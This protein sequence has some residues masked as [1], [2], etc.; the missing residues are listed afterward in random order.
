MKSRIVRSVSFASSCLL[1]VLSIN[2]TPVHAD[3]P[4]PVSE[5]T[6]SVE[7]LRC[8]SLAQSTDSEVSDIKLT[9]VDGKLNVSGSMTFSAPAN[10]VSTAGAG[11]DGTEVASTIPSGKVPNLTG[12]RLADRPHRIQPVSN[13]RTGRVEWS[14]DPSTCTYTLKRTPV[15]QEFMT[16]LDKSTSTQQAARNPTTQDYSYNRAGF[17]VTTRDPIYIPVAA[18][19]VV[20]FWTTDGYNAYHSWTYLDCW[21]ANPTMLNTHW[22][23]DSCSGG[24]YPWQPSAYS[25]C[26]SASGSY[27]NFD[28][29]PGGSPYESTGAMHY[30]NFCTYGPWVSSVNFSSWHWGEGWWLLSGWLEWA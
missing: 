28:G 6:T 16:E 9:I 3:D 14:I 27:Y 2:K 10:G 19:T 25:L 17:R 11:S 13:E 26:Y 20:G 30:V 4:P 1:L 12:V 7:P 15:S 21:G 8:A 29:P 5:A 22:Y 24:G 23:S 18:T